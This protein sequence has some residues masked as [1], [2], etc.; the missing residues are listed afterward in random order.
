MCYT[1]ET[2]ALQNLFSHSLTMHIVYNHQQMKQLKTIYNHLCLHSICEHVA[3]NF[4]GENL[5]RP[6]VCTRREST[7]SLMT[8][9]KGERAVAHIEAL[10]GIRM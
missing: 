8:Y 2:R 9:V 5:L 1:T 4:G 6:T 3:A 7:G 10:G